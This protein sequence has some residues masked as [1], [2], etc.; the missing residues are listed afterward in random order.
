MRLDQGYTLCNAFSVTSFSKTLQQQ[1]TRL[2]DTA[3]YILPT[4]LLCG[5]FVPQRTRE[6]GDIFLAGCEVKTVNSPFLVP[7]R[8]KFSNIPFG[9][10]PAFV[11][12]RRRLKTNRVRYWHLLYFKTGTERVKI[13]YLQM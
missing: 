6:T 4:E 12:V 3:P 8:L 2:F 11:H 7:S 9:S 1:L 5:S 13:V 10:F